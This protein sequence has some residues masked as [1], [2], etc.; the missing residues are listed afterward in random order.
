MDGHV[1]LYEIPQPSL[2]S[3]W[4]KLPLYEPP[5]VKNVLR[6]HQKLLISG[7]SKSGKTSLAIQLA[8]AVAEGTCWLENECAQGG[9]LF[10]NFGLSTYMMFSRVHE[11]YS[12]LNIEPSNVE[13][14]DVI[15]YKGNALADNYIHFMDSIQNIANGNK[16]RLIIIDSIDYVQGF[17]EFEASRHINRLLDNLMIQTNA[18]IAFTTSAGNPPIETLCDSVAKLIPTGDKAVSD[19]RLSIENNTY[20]KTDTDQQLLKYEY[21]TMQALGRYNFK[22][23]KRANNLKKEKSV[24]EFEEAFYKLSLEGKNVSVL[25]LA[26]HLGV[27]RESLYRRIKKLDNFEVQLGIVKPVNNK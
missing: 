15:N 10:V 22:D 26:D 7:A 24:Q 3:V 6:R 14:I 12:S 20:Q 4:E 17:S 5:L 18:C 16:Y 23:V 25:E 9:V 19:F 11:I 27:A 21:P 13:Q 1:E 2:M 8:I